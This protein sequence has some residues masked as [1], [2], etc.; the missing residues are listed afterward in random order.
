MNTDDLISLLAKDAKALPS[1]SPTRRFALTLVPSLAVCTALVLTLWGI[2]PGLFSLADV[3]AFWFKMGWLVALSACAWALMQR[4]S[5]PA[6]RARG[7]ANGLALTVAVLLVLGALQWSIADESLRPQLVRGIS[8][9][10][11]TLSIAALS[12]PVLG[13]LL[14]TLKGLAPTRPGAAGAAAGLMAGAL[15]ALAYSL[16]CPEL[17]FT[18]LALWYGA[19]I[20]AMTALGALIG[21][22]VLR[23]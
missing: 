4:L 1:P 11:C 14:W 19:A 20:S 7:P 5:V 2:N 3:P 17:A 23:W 16:H 21:R 9:R 10:T 13:V 6:K 15:A 18:F 22:R 8:W 12:M